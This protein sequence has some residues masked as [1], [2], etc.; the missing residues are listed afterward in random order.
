MLDSERLDNDARSQHE[1]QRDH[2]SDLLVV[3]QHVDRQREQ[4]EHHRNHQREREHPDME[5]R[6]DVVPAEPYLREHAPQ[7]EQRMQ[8]DDY[9]PEAQELA[10]EPHAV[11]HR[12]GVGQALHV[13]V[14][15]PPDQLSGEKNG[16]Q[17]DRQDRRRGRIAH[18][19][20]QRSQD[21][22]GRGQDRRTGAHAPQ[23]LQRERELRHHHEGHEGP[24]PRGRHLA[25]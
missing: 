9:E 8:R 24:D 10:G 23:R 15:V 2:V 20:S 14:A 17:D 22:I 12:G 25:Q 13:R 4:R 3:H 21:D 6:I 18:S 5:P 16:Q 11:R 1:H 19:G 7:Y